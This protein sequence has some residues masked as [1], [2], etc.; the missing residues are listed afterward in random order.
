MELCL[1]QMSDEWLDQ[2]C[3]FAL[4]NER[5]CCGNDCFG[6]R[7]PHGPEEEDGKLLDEPLERTPIVQELHK[8]NEKDNGRYC[9]L[10]SCRDYR[11]ETYRMY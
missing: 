1:S 6:A 5:R 9:E 3:R 4:P 2:H 11:E 8:G 10:A 7:N